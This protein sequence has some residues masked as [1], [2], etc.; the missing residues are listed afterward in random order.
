MNSI[1]KENQELK[2]KIAELEKE[3]NKKN[4]EIKLRDFKLFN[5][6]NIAEALSVIKTSGDL[7]KIIESTCVGFFKSKPFLIFF[8]DDNKNY[9]YLIN[10]WKVKSFD[11]KLLIIPSTQTLHS[12]LAPEKGV[13]ISLEKLYKENGIDK[14]LYDNLTTLGAKLAVPLYIKNR[15]KGFFVIG[16]RL[17][18]KEYSLDDFELLSIIGLKTIISKENLNLFEETLNANKLLDEANKKL[19]ES[20]NNQKILYEK[21]EAAYKELKHLDKLKDDFIVLISHELNT[22][23]TIIKS[24]IESLNLGFVQDDATAKEFYKA[25]EDETNRLI[26][27]IQTI[28]EMSRLEADK[29]CYNFTELNIDE[30]INNSIRNFDESLKEKS[31]NLTKN[32]DSIQKRKIVGDEKYIT[33]VVNFI[34][35]NAIKFSHENGQIEIST[36]FAETELI[37]SISDNG[38]GIDKNDFSKVF[39]KFEQVESMLHHREGLG[40]SLVMAKLIIERVHSGKIWFESV[41]N[42]GTTFYFSIPYNLKNK[43]KICD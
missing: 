18:K 26:K 12:L 20:L 43:F 10:K 6:L 11:P 3:L 14:I 5:I 34:L 9:F 42:Q 15:A 38:I 30:I 24:Y 31:L 28:I 2:L 21:L 8:Y 39:Q 17:D 41:L 22:P 7:A 33:K 23:V 36:R 29:I 32:I 1:E 27:L 35:D 13:V 16:N 37:I 19:K 40:V 25:I 4:Q